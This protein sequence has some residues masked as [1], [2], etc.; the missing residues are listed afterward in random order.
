MKSAAQQ[1]LNLYW[2]SSCFSYVKNQEKD[3]GKGK[4]TYLMET[5]RYLSH[6]WQEQSALLQGCTGAKRAKWV[7]ERAHYGSVRFRSVSV[8]RLPVLWRQNKSP[9]KADKR[10]RVCGKG[11]IYTNEGTFSHRLRETTADNWIKNHEQRVVR[12]RLRQTEQRGVRRLSFISQNKNKKG[13]KP[14]S[15]DTHSE[16][17]KPGK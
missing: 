3:D 14:S 17:T 6:I 8:N 1:L 9:I 2:F 11:G 12:I 10:D 15:W 7:R 5:K 16:T 13:E 4:I